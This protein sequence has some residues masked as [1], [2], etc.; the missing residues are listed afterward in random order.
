MGQIHAA[1][2]GL[3]LVLSSPGL[4][5]AAAKP[6][7][8][9]LGA[10]K[11][12]PYSIAGD[13]AGAGDDEKELRVRPLVIDAKIKEWTTGDAHDVTD[14]SFA[15][16]RAIRLNDA[17]PTEK[18]EHWVWQRGPWLLVDRATGHVTAIK[19]P[20]YDPAVSSVVWFRDY[21]AYCGLTAT[22][23]QLYAVVAQVAA[24]KPVLAKKLGAW[25]PEDHPKPACAPSTWQR[26]PLRITFQAT[27]AEQISYDLVGLSAVLVEDGDA[28]DSEN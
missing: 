6:H 25:D 1:L 8:V 14:R 2:W 27:G 24:R 3:A 7:I 26:E 21:A 5:F 16:R 22:G 20:N 12:V 19:L 4:L 23:R 11:K 10:V 17:L 15:V 13:P 28:V 9:A 18:N